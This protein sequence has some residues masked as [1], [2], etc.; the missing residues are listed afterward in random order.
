MVVGHAKAELSERPVAVEEE[1]NQPALPRISPP[2]VTVLDGIVDPAEYVIGPGDQFTIVFTGKIVDRYT[3]NVTPEGILLVP[4]FGPINV[5]DLTLADAKRRILSALGSRYMNVSISVFLTELRLV[6]VAVTG[7]VQNQGIYTLS[8]GDRVSEAIRMAGGI[9]EGASQRNIRLFREDD[10][11][12]V[13]LMKYFRAGEREANPYVSEGDIVV[14]PSGE[15]RINRIGLY[16]AVRSPGRFEYSPSDR[17]SG[18]LKLAYGLSTSADS[19]SVEIV[20][21]DDDHVSTKTIIVNLPLGS[22]WADSVAK[23]KL[24]PDDQVYF[25]SIPGFHKVAQVTIA[26]E[27]LYP[28]VYS[29]IEDSTRLSE[30]IKQ[31]GGLTEN[32]SLSE[33]QMDRIGFESLGDE[34]FERKLKLS[35]DKLDDV[36]REILEHQ[37][38]ERP[39]RVSVDFRKLLIE[40]DNSYDITLKA[41]DRIYFPRLSHTV[42]VIGKVLRPGLVEFLPGRDTKYYIKQAGGPGWKAN[43]GKVR[44]VKAVSGAIVKP[45]KR[46]SIEIGDAVIVPERTDRDWWKTIRDVGMFLANLATVYVVVD[47]ALE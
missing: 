41:G 17:L 10:I 47:R 8:A 38:A 2:N 16:G 5:A 21:F 39:G 40:K 45:S 43:T 19:S 13:D 27:V 30:I 35:A 3:L 18:L 28:G 20:R 33:A 46:V 7:E 42:H 24:F 9:L 11:I 12:H 34:A 4:E 36:E 37:L 23:I 32:A 14:V 22:V 6:K 15:N 25:R 26:G 44:I 31:A 29:I 1:K